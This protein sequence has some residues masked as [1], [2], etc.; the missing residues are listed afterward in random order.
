MERQV[1][2]IFFITTELRAAVAEGSLGTYCSNWRLEVF[3]I[4]QF[5]G[6]YALLSCKQLDKTTSITLQI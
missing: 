4:S 2:L 6:K 1:C 3:Y 5:K